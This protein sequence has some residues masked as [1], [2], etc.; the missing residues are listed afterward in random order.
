[1]TN[2]TTTTFTL[3]PI[4]AGGTVATLSRW[5]KNPGDP[6]T[7]GEP[8]LEV[9]T[10]KV[11]TE[12][13][14]PFSGTLVR[15]LANEEDTIEEGAEL[16]VIEHLT[17][18]Q[19]AP[20]PHQP[21]VVVASQD[22]PAATAGAVA[23][24]A[25][26]GGGGPIGG[27]SRRVPVPASLAPAVPSVSAAV[28][29]GERREKLTPI[30]RVIADRMM[31]SLQS[32]AQLTTVVEVDVTAVS[33]MR[34]SYKAEGRKISYLPFFIKA[35]IEALQVY[36]VFNTTTANSGTELVYHESVNLGIAVDSPKGLMVPVVRD[37]QTKGVDEIATAVDDLA[38]RVRTGRITPGDMEGGTFTITNTGSRGSL[39]DTP[40]LNYPQTAILGTGAVVERVVPLPSEEVRIGIR[41]FV[42]LALT[43]DHRIVDGADAARFLSQIKTHIETG[44]ADRI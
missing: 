17:T 19:P 18:A 31:E 15:I 25:A 28:R 12:I 13:S 2:T 26:P 30:R 9:A 10:D 4:G 33:R 32:T 20:S 36:P 21:P 22:N 44:S 27:P 11:D 16:A 23:P 3:P 42:Y 24:A 7:D 41:S 40:I 34:K 14:A 43:Y 5:L 35:A 8:L 6:I 39:F 37:A 1:M 29:P 38:G